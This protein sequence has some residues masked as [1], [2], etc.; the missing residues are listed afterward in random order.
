MAKL[1]HL[2]RPHVFLQRCDLRGALL[3]ESDLS[4]ARFADCDLGS[5]ELFNADLAG[6][7][8]RG[9]EPDNLK[10]VAYLRGATIDALQLFAVAPAL[11]AH[12]GRV[13]EEA[14]VEGA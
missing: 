9:N 3:V 8:L 5:L 7:D 10:G 11:A 12:L 13:V 14:D 4:E 6:T 2:G 1:S